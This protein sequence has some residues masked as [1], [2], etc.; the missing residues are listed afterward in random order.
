MMAELLFSERHVLAE[1]RFVEMVV[2][3]VPEPVA[4]SRH[5]FRYRLALIVDDRCVLR[6]DNE[7][8]NGDHRHDGA[9]ESPYRFTTP[10]NL[11]D[12]FWH[13]VDRWRPR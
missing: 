4:G 1:N 2:W 12:D 5:H 6:Y 11:F 13:D 7:S 8:G 9:A 10:Q 3:R